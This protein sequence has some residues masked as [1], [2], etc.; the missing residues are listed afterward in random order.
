MYFLRAVNEESVSQRLLSTLQRC[1]KAVDRD[2]CGFIPAQ[3]LQEVFFGLS[4]VALF[5][6]AGSQVMTTILPFFN[7]QEW[8][9]KYNI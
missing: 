8:L 4:F 5:V 3:R 1:F 9:C 2:E 7:I 6:F